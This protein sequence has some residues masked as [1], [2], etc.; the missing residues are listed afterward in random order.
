VF[1]GDYLGAGNAT[2]TVSGN[3]G[4][5]W[6]N[7]F[8]VTPGTLVNRR[9]LICAPTSSFTYEGEEMQ[10]QGIT[11]TAYN[12]ATPPV[13]TD[14]YAGSFAKFNGSVIANFNFGAVDLADAFPPLTATALTTNLGLVSSTGSWTTG[15]GTINANVMLNRAA[16]P[17]GPYESFRLGIAPFDS[18]DVTVR[19][20]DLNLDT[21]VPPDSNDRVL[22]GSTKVRFGRLWLGNAYGTEKR[23]LTLSYETQ[24]WNGYAF[25]NNLDDAC[26]TL[27]AANFGL[28]NYQG[29]L[30]TS[31]T[32]VS[33]TPGN[34]FIT[35]AAPN[36]AGSVDIV[37]T[38]G[39]PLSMCP[40]TWTPVSPG[41]SYVAIY[42]RGNWGCS[43]TYDKDP[44]ARA[45]FGIF[46]D[47]TKKTGPIY[48]RENF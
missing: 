33:N 12:A 19:N 34:R 43:G 48:L 1:D 39:N 21:T 26:T 11:L 9:L 20:A 30:T 8:V 32:S 10:V 13:R 17:D 45:T 47:S 36:A 25:I 2:G 40:T 46:G 15:T 23:N 14:N 4:R 31:I 29:A 18:D 38:L 27:A 35:L 41:T 3:V 28:G 22:A 6:P 44:V 24:Y 7:H 37:A 42:L 16:S 5:F